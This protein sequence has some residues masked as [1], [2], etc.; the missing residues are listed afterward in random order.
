MANSGDVIVINNGK[1]TKTGTGSNHVATVAGSLTVTEN[2]TVNGETV[3]LK[4]ATLD[5]E[6]KNITLNK[7]DGDSSGSANGAGITIQDAVDASTDATILWD[8]TNDEFVFSHGVDVPGIKVGGSA[9]ATTDLSGNSGARGTTITGAE[10]SKLANIENNATR[11]QSGAEIK[12]ALFAESDTNNLTDTLLAKLN[13]IEASA[14]ADQTKSD[15]D[16]LGIA[17]STAAT[18][19]NTRT[20]AGKNFNGS[21]DITIAAADLSDV[22]SAGSG[23]I[24]TSDERTKLANIEANADVTDAINVA[25]ATAVMDADFGSAGFMKRG[26]DA[27]SYSVAASIGYGD[28]TNSDI[29][30][31]LSNVSSNHDSLAS[32]KAIKDFVDTQVQASNEASE[33]TVTNGGFVNKFFDPHEAISPGQFLYPASNNKVGVADNTNASK[34]A[35]IGVAF[36]S[37]SLAVTNASLQFVVMGNVS[38]VANGDSI[39][40]NVSA[41]GNA[42]QK[43]YRLVATTGDGSSTWSGDGSNGNPYLWNIKRKSNCRCKR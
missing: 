33:F 8:A 12:T 13:G 37:A 26:G 16:A 1:L 19:A 28:L 27:G 38:S 4:T 15:I 10:G 31:D 9:L 5:V 24:I 25:N 2:L 39:E 32:A 43:Y 17:A 34:D 40:W 23:A 36:D 29:D 14:T 30:T 35:V 6:D 11:D 41:A 20:I 22:T 3:T 7:A 18:L 21:A 42:T